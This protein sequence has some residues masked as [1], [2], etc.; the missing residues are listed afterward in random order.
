MTVEN[1]YTKDCI[2][3][4]SGKYMNIFEPTED[5][6]C[7]VDIAHAL[8]MQTR[9]GGHLPVFYSVAQH[10]V[11]TSWLSKSDKFAALMHDASEAYLLDLP[12]PIKIRMPIYKEIE[13][14]LMLL[15]AKKFDFNYPLS[16][17]VKEADE[18]IL[19]QEWDTIMLQKDEPFWE[20]YWTPAGARSEFLERFNQLKP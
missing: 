20:N 4:Y 18:A 15:I 11:K 8:S 16:K 10:S 9:F 6:I 1:L 14:N 3:T 2:R 19:Q 17:D 5:M 7:I 12:R 13:H